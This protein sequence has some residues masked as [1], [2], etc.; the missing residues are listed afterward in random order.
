MTAADAQGIT[1]SFLAS[2]ESYQGLREMQV[3]NLIIPVVGNFAGTRA[4]KSVAA[5]LDGRGLTVTVFYTSNVES[6]LFR[7]D[8]WRT[9]YGNMA[10]LPVDRRSVLVRSVFEGSGGSGG[11]G[12]DYPGTPRQGSLHFDPIEDLV[13]AFRRGEI[14]GYGDLLARSR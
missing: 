6:Y 9:F 8:D 1:R 13:A 10:A 2:E 11:A 3:R 12:A 7:G 5:Y 4:L 14:S